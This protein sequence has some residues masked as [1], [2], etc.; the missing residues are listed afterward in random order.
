MTI[1][2]PKPLC[3]CVFFF[4]TEIEITI[5]EAVLY[6]INNLNTLIRQKHWPVFLVALGKLEVV[7]INLLVFVF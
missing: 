5:H 3:V 6:H 2:L 1:S 7:V 4:L